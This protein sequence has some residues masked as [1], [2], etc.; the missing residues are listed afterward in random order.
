[1]G[2]RDGIVEK[3]VETGSDVITDVI[4][5]IVNDG[6]VEMFSDVVAEMLVTS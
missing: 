5:E 1:M 6:I 3:L 4:V 2:V